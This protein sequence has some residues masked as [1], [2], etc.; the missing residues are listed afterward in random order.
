[1]YIPE[2]FV[3]TYIVDVMYIGYRREYRSSAVARFRQAA[4]EKCC[5][6][7]KR[8]GNYLFILYMVTKILYIAQALFQ[9]FAL[10]FVIG[11]GQY[12]SASVISLLAFRFNLSEILWYSRI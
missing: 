6:V 11:E 10:N 4:G 2:C 7:G 8:Y 1:M 5:M 9:L 3:Y 12:I